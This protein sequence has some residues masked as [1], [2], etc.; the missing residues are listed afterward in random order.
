MMDCGQQQAV[1]GSNQSGDAKV[2]HPPSDRRR[3]WLIRLLAFGIWT[4]LGV[5]A[6]SQ[7]YLVLYSVTKAGPDLQNVSPNV[8]WPELLRATLAELYL[9]GL[10]SV[11]I[12][13]LGRRFSLGQGRW[14]RNVL[15]HLVASAV[16]ALLQTALMVLVSQ[17]VRQAIPKPTVSFQVLQLY[18]FAKL[19]ANMFYYWIILG[20]GQLLEY[21]RKYR[22]RELEAA[23][24]QAQ[25]A[26]AQLQVL[27][28]QLHPHFLFNTL[29]AISA[30]IHQD[31]ELA[32]R[33]I[34]RL[35]DLLRATL[36]NVNMQD[37]SL[38]EELDFIR[39]YLEIEQARLGS[40][41]A[42]QFAI[43]P[44]VLDAR[45]P[46]LILQPLVENAIRHG[47]APRAEGGRVEIR[48]RREQTAL[49]LEVHDD[50]PGLA[51][52]PQAALKK[53]LGLANTR[54]RLEQLYGAGH[55]FEL[56]ND[57]GLRVA[58]TLPF[59]ECL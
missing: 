47:V 14:V 17:F 9:W 43:E 7:T 38:R 11:P 55:Q 35:G 21:F 29:H 52:D 24:L 36:E 31:V 32:D 28:M 30:L 39:P 12:F 50:G 57:R 58:V 42:I 45:V 5:F 1:D 15:I 16:F 51:Q 53:G 37:V 2:M 23:Q 13:W 4:F 46:N 40:R 18:V 33:M 3:R 49:R 44:E 22:A 26:A 6:F 48:A 25:L 59:H 27:K 34:A 56:C 10:L 20:V 8:P 19:H 41:L 54:A